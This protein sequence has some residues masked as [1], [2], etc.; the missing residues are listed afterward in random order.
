MKKAS[1]TCSGLV[2]NESFKLENYKDPVS[3]F[4]A[5]LKW[6]IQ[7]KKRNQTFKQYLLKVD[8][9]IVPSE[10][11]YRR[12]ISFLGEENK[13][14]VVKIQHGMNI[15]K[16]FEKRKVS[17]DD[18]IKILYP[19]NLSIS[20]GVADVER[21][22]EKLEKEYDNYELI[23]AGPHEEDSETVR[24]MDK[25]QNL[26]NVKYIGKYKPEERFDLFAKSD[27]VLI[28]SQWDDIYNLVLDEALV[29]K[30]FV[31]VTNKG[32]MPERVVEGE[33]GFIYEVDSTGNNL[34][35][36]IKKILD[37]PLIL[38]REAPKKWLSQKEHINEVIKVYN[39][40]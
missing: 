2:L 39:A 10:F 16:D 22:F 36:A 1:G 25:L 21:A 35:E 3:K 24:F 33:N 9:M 13:G 26:N 32:A 37:N 40:E 38:N 19:S 23:L 5:R 4:I 30:K 27:L 6:M 28:P 7:R 29:T 20:K 17:S 11:L 34:Y 31:I 12:L 15:D 8:K 18:K 14:R